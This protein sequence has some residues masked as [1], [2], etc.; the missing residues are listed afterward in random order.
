MIYYIG[1]GSNIGDREEYL[2]SAF[3]KVRRLQGTEVTA[4]SSLY[5]T[6]PVGYIDQ[7]PFLNAVISIRSE[8]EPLEL[9]DRLQSI[10]SSLGRQRTIRWGP[11]TID[12]DILFCDK[13]IIQTERL[14]I[15]HPRAKER[16]FVMIPLSE[17]APEFQVSEET[18]AG[19][20]MIRLYKT[21]WIQDCPVDR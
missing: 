3:N 21:L 20:S 5:E 16:S 7:P 8:L 1:M 15:P 17:I 2:L 12:L 6:E 13:G 14:T 11:R 18:A 4:V 10:E 9:L 19:D